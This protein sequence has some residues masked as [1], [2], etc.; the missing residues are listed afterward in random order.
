MLFLDIGSVPGCEKRLLLEL[1]AVTPGGR[2]L[3]EG[4]IY[5][6]AFM[7]PELLLITFGTYIMFEREMKVLE[8]DGGTN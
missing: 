3:P 6:R 8:L 7:N 1:L 5:L 2:N 4:G